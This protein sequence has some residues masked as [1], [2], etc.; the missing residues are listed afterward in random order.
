MEMHNSFKS[1]RE[2]LPYLPERYHRRWLESGDGRAIFGLDQRGGGNRT[3]ARSHDGDP[4][5]TDHAFIAEQLLD[6]YDVEY[7]VCTGSMWSVGTNADPLYG[8]ACARAYNDWQVHDFLPRDDR[9]LGAIVISPQ[10]VESA[11]EEIERMAGQPRMVEVIISAATHLPLGH[12]YY[13]PLFAAAARHG[14]PVATHT[15]GEGRGNTGVPTPA[16]YPSRYLEYHTNLALN[17]MA[18]LASLVC[19]DLFVR[20]PA[21]RIVLMEGGISWVPP[22]LWRLDRAWELHRDDLAHLDEPPSAYVPRHFRF[23]TQPVEEPADPN[24][25]LKTWALVQPERT[26]VFASDYPHWDADDAYHALP[27]RTPPDVRRRILRENARELFAKKL[28][29]LEA[30][31]TTEASR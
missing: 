28:A 14:L 13:R 26:L 12:P 31:E 5:A 4:P 19:S 3:D 11:A 22:L 23:G 1:R 25:V 18:Q 24:H 29:V 8:A 30:G 20:Y 2:L 6:P 9:Y 16:G 10:D 15:T 21:L 27:P 7:V 17:P